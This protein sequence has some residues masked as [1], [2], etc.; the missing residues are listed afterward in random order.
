[1]IKAGRRQGGG[2]LPRLFRASGPHKVSSGA[3]AH[4]HAQ[5][6]QFGLAR[7]WIAPGEAIA[8][9]THFVT[10]VCNARCAHCFYPINAGKNE[11]TLEEIDRFATTLPPIRLLLISGGEPFLR[12][13]LP[14]LIRVYFERCGFFSASIPTNGFSPEEVARGAE[15][16]CSFSPDLRSA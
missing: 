5:A 8:Q 1:M 15:K 10:S 7:D 16:I 13:D 12:R 14:D 2:S 6:R 4:E 3:Q 11:L 9:W